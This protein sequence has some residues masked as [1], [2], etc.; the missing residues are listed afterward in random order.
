[1]HLNHIQKT[2]LS[3]IITMLRFNLE[4]QLFY[5]LVLMKCIYQENDDYQ[6]V[7]VGH[8]LYSLE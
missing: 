1:M 2:K 8:V 4:F 3:N 7:V 6:C 5:H